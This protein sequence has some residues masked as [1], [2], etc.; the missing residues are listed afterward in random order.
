MKRT[1]RAAGALYLVNIV[2]GAFAIG[3][4]SAV[5]GQDVRSHELVFRLGLAAHIGV[6]LTNIGLAMLFYE[7]F[8]VVDRR[9][10]LLVVFFTLVA[11]AIEAAGIAAQQASMSLDTTQAFYDVS[12]AF[13][14]GYALALGYLVVRS[15][16]LPQVI[17]WLMLLD[18]AAYLVNS[19][20][21][22]IA[23]GFAAHL[24]PLI[25][26][27]ILLGE[28]SLCLWLLIAGVNEA[29]WKLQWE[30]SSSTSS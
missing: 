18:G 29:R 1:A 7:L 21:S 5:V 26:L 6:T 17:G 12:T 14:G 9:L 15:T 25:Q 2:L 10:A 19:F 4:V 16:F 23:P 20:A 28:G 3:V 22:V 30:K 13:F 8:K 11:T 27:P 24:V